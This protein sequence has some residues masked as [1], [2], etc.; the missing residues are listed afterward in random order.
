MRYTAPFLLLIIIASCSKKEVVQKTNS[1][2]TISD[3]LRL[4]Q[5]VDSLKVVPDINSLK[6]EDALKIDLS[7]FKNK[8]LR[9]LKFKLIPTELEGGA[10]DFAESEED[11][12]FNLTD[13]NYFAKWVVIAKKPKFFVILTDEAFLTTLNYNLEKIDAIRFNYISPGSNNHWS[14]NRQGTIDKKLTI[15]LHHEYAV[16]VDED[17]NFETTTLDK[18]YYI[19]SEGKIQN[20]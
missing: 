7:E 1:S 12:L 4:L 3:S 5:H 15:V 17:R 16:Q 10:M 20:K 13:E 2:V 19:N 11:T 14:F 6:P 18:K 9:N 8:K